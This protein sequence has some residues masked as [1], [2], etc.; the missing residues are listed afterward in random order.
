MK[1]SREVKTGIIVLTGILAFIFGLSYLKSSS[2]FENHKTLYAVYDHVGGI[3]S[4]TQ[5]TINGVVVG[6]VVGIKFKDNKFKSVVTF[7]VNEGYEFSKN[8]SAEIYDTGIIG[9]KGVQ[10]HPVFDGAPMA[11]SG[12][13]L[14]SS[15][16][17]GLTALVQ[18]KLTPLQLK[19]E[20][21]VSHADSLLI[22]V[23][24]VLDDRTRLELRQSIAG[25]NELISS[26]KSSADKLNT[27]LES[28]KGQLDRSL[29]N[30]DK[31]TGNFSKLSDSLANSGLA[32]T[33]ANFQTTVTR[34][35][36]VLGKIEQGEGSLGKLANDEKLYENLTE[37]SKQLDLL[38]QD[39]RLNPK[40]YVNVSVFGKKQ[41]DYELPE[42]D[43]AE[44]NQN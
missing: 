35:N 20:G 32:E 1:L 37:A 7:S 19:V 30:V 16:K 27:L 24:D 3:Q 42:N 18:E 29:K 39:F 44:Q 14:K 25:L 17:P 13:T 38:L 40:R 6:N 15:I 4:G 10:I 41:K 23:N 12:D 11:I 28:N 26:F 36:N 5:V 21:A 43:P 22:N 2:L 9:G 34:L 31:I 8:S 33:V